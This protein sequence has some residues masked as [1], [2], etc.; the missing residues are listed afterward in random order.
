VY[1]HILLA[2]LYIVAWLLESRILELV[3]DVIA[4]QQ[5]GKRVSAAMINTTIENTV[6][7]I[8]H[9]SGQAVG[10]DVFCEV[11]AEVI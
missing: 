8:R 7:S 10:D 1:I 5:R 4:R 2:P 6:F 9:A 3:G 11:R